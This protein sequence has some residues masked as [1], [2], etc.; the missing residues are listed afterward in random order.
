MSSL[1]SA[2]VITLTS[3]V[4][5]A[6]CARDKVGTM[7]VKTTSAVVASM[8]GHKTYAYESIAPAPEGTVQ[9]GGATVA[10]AQVKERI[11]GE[12]QAKGY[13]LDPN[14]ELLIRISIGVKTAIDEPQGTAALNNAP[15][16]TNTV[17]AMNI[18][19]FDL[20]NN[21]HLFHGTSQD[22]LH[23]REV[24]GDKLAKAVRLILEP[25]PPAAR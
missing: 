16:M 18:D 19:I 23:H 15:V 5:L 9:W 20:A 8:A 22:E 17:T 14:P 25:I 7:Q 2:A 10:I 13:V 4:L 21:G 3:L 11:D 12:M 1:R 24:D 6:G